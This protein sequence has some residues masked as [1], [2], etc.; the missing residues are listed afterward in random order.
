MSHKFVP[1]AYGDPN[2]C[3]VEG[4]SRLRLSHESP[5]PPEVMALA[6]ALYYGLADNGVVRIHADGAK[7]LH[8]VARAV[9][10]ALPPHWRLERPDVLRRQVDALRGADYSDEWAATNNYQAGIDAVLTLLD[11]PL[12]PVD[13][14]PWNDL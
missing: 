5:W 14:E 11:D 2:L 8:D 3:A 4:C 13:D 1:G 10:E 7:D 12:N 9:L 6:S